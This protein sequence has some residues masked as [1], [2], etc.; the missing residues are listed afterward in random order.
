MFQQ[1][2]L[3]LYK[4]IPFFRRTTVIPVLRHVV[5]IP[6]SLQFYKR[7]FNLLTSKLGYDNG[8]K[9]GVIQN[10]TFPN[11]LSFPYYCYRVIIGKQTY[12]MQQSLH[13]PQVSLFVLATIT[14]RY[15]EVA[16]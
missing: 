15:V 4:V 10:E 2:C 13:P 5:K 6:Q 1:S 11:N 14:F 8:S 3:A 16:T 9:Y 7:Q 12:K